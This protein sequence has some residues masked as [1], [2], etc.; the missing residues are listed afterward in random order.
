MKAGLVEVTQNLSSGVAATGL[1]VIHDTSRGGENDV[2]ELAGRQETGNPLLDL[3]QLDVETGGDDTG[4]VDASN[5]LDNDL[6]GAVVIDLL[7]LANVAY[8]NE[9]FFKCR[10]RRKMS[11]TNIAG[12]ISF[13]SNIFSVRQTKGKK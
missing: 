13:Q 6:A 5:E 4:L 10:K 9:F 7:E 2:A 3:V 1:L 11:G 12:T 8:Y